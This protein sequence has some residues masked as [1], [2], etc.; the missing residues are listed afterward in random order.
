MV[1]LVQGAV[2]QLIDVCGVW[3]CDGSKVFFRRWADE[4]KVGPLTTLAFPLKP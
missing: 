4:H 2:T 1:P 3:G